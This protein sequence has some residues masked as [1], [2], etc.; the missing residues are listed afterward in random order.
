MRPTLSAL[1]AAL[2]LCLP[3]AGMAQQTGVRVYGILDVFAGSAN[4][5]GG[6]ASRVINNGGMTTS[7][8]GI[9]GKEELG[10]GLKTVFALE[11]VVRLDT[12]ESGRFPN[13]PLFSRA[14]YV[15]LSGDFGT[16]KLGRVPN[17]LFQASAAVNPYAY[18]TRFSPLMTQLWAAPY[19][20]AVTGDTGWSNAL[21][22]TSPTLGGVTLVGQYAPGETPGSASHN[23][24]AV[25]RYEVGPLLLVAGGQ[26]VE[27]GL[28]ITSAAPRQDTWLAGVAY[29][30]R[31]VKL[32]GSYD[33]NRTDLTG[34][35]TRTA[36]LG[37]QVP[38]GSGRYLLAWARSREDGLNRP[39]FR[40]DTATA[41]Y[42]YSLSVRTD[43]YAVFVYDK[44]ST[45]SDG[46][47]T[48]LGIRHKF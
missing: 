17:P 20:S 18:S 37:L 40:R 30:L 36:Q 35:R 48:A 5:S 16:V 8:Y 24:A 31:A 32:Y 38:S 42:D 2:L 3:I 4:T 34:R 25:L 6:L 23:A 44:L 1:A 15:G 29:D 41:G 26:R 39:E 27:A 14:A 47:T 9:G 46:N 12:G 13:D 45:S 21:H 7:Y 11:G 10:Q 22:Y 43:V 33:R 19:G 28:G